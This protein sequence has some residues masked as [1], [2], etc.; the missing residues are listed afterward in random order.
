MLAAMSQTSSLPAVVPE[1]PGTPAAPSRRWWT[2]VTVALAQLMVV[3]DSTVV[4]I[5]LP[6]RPAGPRILQ[7]R[8]PVDRHRLLAGLRQ[9]A[10]ARRPDLRPD[11][12]QARLHHR[13]HR[14]RRGLGPGRGRRLVRDARR[15]PGAPG[16]V[17]RT[18]GAHRAG[19]ADHDVHRSEGTRPRVRH[20]RRHRGSG[21]SRGPAP[22]WRAHR[23]VQLALEP[24]HQRP[25]RH[26]RHHRRRPL[27][28]LDGPQRPAP[29]AGHPG[30]DPRLRRAVLAGLRLLERR[31]RRLG[32]PRHLGLPRRVRR[33]PDRLRALAAS[34][35]ASPPS[36]ADRAP[37]QPRGLVQLDSHRRRGDV[38]HL[39]LR[40]LLPADDAEVHAHPDRAGLPADDHHA[41]GVGTALHQPDA[42]AV[43]P[44]GRGADRDADR[45]RPGWCT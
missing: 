37:P 32:L 31:D 11:R 16:R 23:A 21:R 6:V 15:R 14:L 44:E 24:L 38:R 10:A 8:P 28:D 17:R 13:P 7:R 1:A 20:L 12:P 41:G 33:A 4:N 42:A 30:H 40:H 34:R 25:H 18:A 27:R 39:P 3:L 26:H 2:L 43:R 29:E 36:A 35:R 5:A 9:P 22:R 19:R 45:G